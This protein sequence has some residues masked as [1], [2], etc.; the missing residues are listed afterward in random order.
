M[1]W[2]RYVAVGDSFTE[3]LEDRLPH[4]RH[5][6]WADRLAARLA[7]VSPDFHY[8]NLAVRGQRLPQIVGSQVPRAVA[9]EP[10]LVSIAAGVNDVLRPRFDLVRSTTL[11][12]VGV[13]AARSGGADVLLVSF[14]N[15]S[16]RSKA[17]GTVTERL[18][19]YRRA[20]LSIGERYD[21]LVCDLWH[22]TVFDDSRLWA[23]DRLHLNTAGHERMAAAAAESLGLPVDDWRRPLPPA[24]ARTVL[25]SVREDAAWTARHLG[26][27]VGRRVLGR[28]SGDGVLP[29]REAL[30]PVE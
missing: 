17:L 15:P 24:R 25:E 8:A 26:P 28:S 30:S 7:D 4:G 3:G 19:Q 10:D 6:G 16:R 14:G 5:R 29:K 9:L 23:E 11:L 1:T 12:E 13:A 18:R 2:H 20:L 21:C 22:A 27:W